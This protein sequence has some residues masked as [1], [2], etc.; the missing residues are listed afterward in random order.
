VNTL[1]IDRITLSSQNDVDPPTPVAR[2]I[3]GD[4]FDPDS[5]IP[6][7]SRMTA[8]IKSAEVNSKKPAHAADRNSV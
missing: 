8:I 2:A 4:L 7:V 3:R 6:I 1:V 5:Q